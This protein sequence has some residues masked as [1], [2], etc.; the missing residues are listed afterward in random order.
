MARRSS[1]WTFI[2]YPDSAP[3]NWQ[4]ILK[5]LSIPCAVSPLHDKDLNADDTEKKAHWHIFLEYDS[6]KSYDQVKEDTD[7]FNGTIPKI[8][9]SPIGMIR[10]FIHKDNPEK[11]QY[12][13][14]D[15]TVYNGFDID[16]YDQYTQSELD[17][18][19]ADITK[20][21]D[22][23]QIYEYADLI[24]I[25]RS[26]SFDK[27][28]DWYHIIRTNTIF[29]SKYI[30]SRRCTFQQNAIQKAN[31]QYKKYCEKFNELQEIIEEWKKQK[32]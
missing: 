10:Y 12:K 1:K 31:E 25:T 30:T 19:I 29:F 5:G 2:V 15:I 11:H 21:I 23:N 18:I 13:W 17:Q 7:L 32:K 20:Y 24:A 27:S 6:L 26:K 9:K 16:K 28:E 22:D 8:I 4:Q 3:D 14:A